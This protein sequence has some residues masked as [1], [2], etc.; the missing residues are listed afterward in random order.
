MRIS[1][2]AVEGVYTFS[3]EAYNDNVEV[4]TSKTVSVSGVKKAADSTE[5]VPVVSSMNLKQGATGVYKLSL[6][7]LGNAAQTYSVS[8]EGLDGWGTYEVNPL[9]VTL[10]P[11]ANQ[12][13]DL[14]LTVS[15]KALVGGH[16]F[17]VKVNSD[18]KTVREMTL[19]ANVEKSTWKVDAMLISVVVL[20]IVL[21]ALVAILVRSRKSDEGT[22]V[23]ES[24]Y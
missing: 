24:Y 11:D 6:L 16:A 3:I 2:D 7:N 17:T 4:K 9:K 12:L 14:A 20:A 19:T 15:G 22:E 10:S 1:K 21:V 23:E 18:G 8:V 13:V 5:V